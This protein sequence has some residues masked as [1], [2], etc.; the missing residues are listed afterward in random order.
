[1]TTASEGAGPGAPATPS[2]GTGRLLVSSGTP[3]EPRV[4]YSRAVR[5]GAHVHVSGTTATHRDRVI[6]GDDPTAQAHF[7]IDKLDGAI[8]SLG[9]TLADVV[10]T[11]VFVSRLEDWEP[12]ARAHGERFGEILP[13][14]TLV[15]AGLVGSEY[16]VEMEAEADVGES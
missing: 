13:A 6:G 4:G 3:W 1:V 14:N 9:G 16:L 7:V 2:N 11:R 12:V 8:Q 10:R 5:I 15:R